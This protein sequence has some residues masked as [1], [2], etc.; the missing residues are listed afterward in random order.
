MKDLD[1]RIL[2]IIVSEEFSEEDIQKEFEQQNDDAH[3]SSDEIE[4]KVELDS[5]DVAKV[6]QKYSRET[7]SLSSEGSLPV[8]ELNPGM[9]R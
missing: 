6:C 2:D 7:E 1:D 9:G 3:S 5:R 4:E 8:F